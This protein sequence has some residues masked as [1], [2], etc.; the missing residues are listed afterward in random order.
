ME[1]FDALFEQQQEQAEK[2]FDRNLYTK[3]WQKRRNR[4]KER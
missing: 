1:N 4:E 3:Q 2:P